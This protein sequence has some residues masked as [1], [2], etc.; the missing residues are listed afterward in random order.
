M[1]KYIARIVGLTGILGMLIAPSAHAGQ[2]R[3]GVQIGAP[4][5]VVAQPPVYGGQV[6]GGQ[7]YGGQGYGESV[8]GPRGYVWQ[9][10]YFVRTMFGR[11]WVPGAWV[12]R[13]YG[14]RDW[15]D[16]RGRYER[17]D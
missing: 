6:Y 1:M 10:G 2:V 9:P 4:P 15:R 3:V 11:R 7:G 13:G 12:P 16:D 14:A 5:V 17:Y 8:Y